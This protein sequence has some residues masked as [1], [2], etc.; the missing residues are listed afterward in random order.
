MSR[1]ISPLAPTVPNE[2][3]F[4]VPKTQKIAKFDK[5]G[6]PSEPLR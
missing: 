5:N 6:K 1:P 3:D 4:A 2:L